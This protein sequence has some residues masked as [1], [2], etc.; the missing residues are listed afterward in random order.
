MRINIEQLLDNPDA[1]L[2]RDVMSNTGSSVLIP[3]RV[4]IGKLAEG[5]EKPRKLID[6]LDRMGIRKVEIMVPQDIDDAEMMSRLKELDPSVVVIDNEVTRHAQNVIADI[7]D[8]ASVEEKFSIPV[9]IVKEIGNDLSKEVMKTSQI[10]LSMV[11]SNLD[12]YTKDHA[13][14]VSMLAGYIARK[15]SDAQKAPASLVEKAVQAGLLFD[16]GKTAVPKEILN[17]EEKLTPEE[18]VVVRNHVKES[19]SICKLSGIT[20][21]DLLEGIASHHERYDGSGYERGLVGGQIPLLA[22]IL[23][24]ADTFDAMTSVR[25]YKDAVSSKMSFNFI[26][27]ANETEFDPD[28]CKIFI[29]GMG[30]YPPGTIVELSDGKIATVAAITSGNLLQ[31]KVTLKEGGEQRV[32]DLTAEHLYIKRSMEDIRD[33]L[34]LL[35]I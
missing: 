15:L 23:A 30:V 28:I 19:V 24:V 9:E 11:S 33:T 8:Q 1:Y 27:S 31:P 18:L 2:I 14:N 25:I 21:K 35:A 20:D 22:R 16:I 26:M 32:L 4:P 12:S 7:F 6:T 5:L 3:S 17:K 34:D 13:L 29:A 10:A